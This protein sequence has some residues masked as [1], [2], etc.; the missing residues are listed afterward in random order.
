MVAIN[1]LFFCMACLAGI[2]LI[3][4][5]AIVCAQIIARLLGLYIPGSGD[6]AT[7]AMSAALFLSLPYTLTRGEHIRMT[8]VLELIPSIYERYCEFF[9]TTI[10]LVLST[11]CSYYLGAFVY[12]S[13]IYNELSQGVLAIPMWIPQLAMPVGSALL[14]IAF[15]QRLVRLITRQQLEGSNE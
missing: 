1:K 4:L 2:S 13:Y 3:F 15:I 11:W 8:A 10:A 12:R 6:L 9:V 7:W 14:T 5:A